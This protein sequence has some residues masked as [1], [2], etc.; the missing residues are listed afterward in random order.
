MRM[1]KVHRLHPVRAPASSARVL[2][3]SG[4]VAAWETEGDRDVKGGEDDWGEGKLE[5][6]C[7]NRCSRCD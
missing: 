4:R 3:Q 7:S 2:A 6:V 1:E 5:H